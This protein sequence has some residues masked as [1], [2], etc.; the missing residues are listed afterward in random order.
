MRPEWK[1]TPLGCIALAAA[2]LILPLRFLLAAV[3][4][5]AVHEGCH[6]GAIR[7]CGGRIYAV[8]MGVGKTVIETEPLEGLKGILCAG[9]GPAGS[10]ALLVLAKPF[11]LL[12]LCGLVQGLY[13]LLP[14]YPMDGGRMLRCLLELAAPRIGAKAAETVGW[15]ASAG[16][17]ALC[18]YGAFRLKCAALLL[19]AAPI[20]AAKAVSAKNTLQRTARTG[21]IEKD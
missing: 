13:N 5:A 1:M 8:R 9:A 6:Y 14:I 12:A 10:L 18:A 16:V 20:A 15:A 4:A 2:L 21:T 19:L 7:L 3:A 11:P 17:L